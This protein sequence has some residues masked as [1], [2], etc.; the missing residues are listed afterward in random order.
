M[1][2][3]TMIA[4]G[5]TALGIGISGHM[6]F[7]KNEATALIGMGMITLPFYLLS[8]VM[9]AGNIRI[10]RWLVCVFACVAAYQFF[11]FLWLLWNVNLQDIPLCEAVLGSPFPYDI[12]GT[13]KLAAPYYIVMLTFCGGLYWRNHFIPAALAKNMQSNRAPAS[14][15]EK[16]VNADAEQGRLKSYH[17]KKKKQIWQFMMYGSFVLFFL[18]GAKLAHRDGDTLMFLVAAFLL[19]PLFSYGA[20]SAFFRYLYPFFLEIHDEG[21]KLPN[22]GFVDW[23]N[24]EKIG[25][26]GLRTVFCVRTFETRKIREPLL[27]RYLKHI[28]NRKGRRVLMSFP[29]QNAGLNARFEDIYQSLIDGYAKHIAKKLDYDLDRPLSEIPDSEIAEFDAEMARVFCDYNKIMQGFK[30]V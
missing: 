16:K 8:L 11:W 9:L 27:G 7:E 1:A 6:C 4:L 23:D 3:S 18:L 15:N 26:I 25:T 20:F 17:Y 13:E 22:I 30:R 21:I 5:L 12:S 24:V 10:W 29:T 28:Y 19:I 14:I 2:L